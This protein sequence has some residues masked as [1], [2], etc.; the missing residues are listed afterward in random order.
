MTSVFELA[1]EELFSQRLLDLFL[2]DATQGASAVVRIVS[3]LG[4]ERPRCRC[5]VE[6]DMPRGNLIP[7]FKEELVHDRGHDGGRE[8]VEVDLRVEAVSELRAEHPLELS[9][10]VARRSRVTEADAAPR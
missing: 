6:G 1:E 7:E 3:L 2:D 5:C 9:V 10:R 8:R 4:Q